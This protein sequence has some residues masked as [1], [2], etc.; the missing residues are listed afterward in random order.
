MY[1]L[2]AYGHYLTYLP[3]TVVFSTLE[4]NPALHFK[5]LFS[6]AKL[7]PKPLAEYATIF[8]AFNFLG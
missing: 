7:V 5:S 2:L 4:R 3:Q 6:K 1:I 8:V